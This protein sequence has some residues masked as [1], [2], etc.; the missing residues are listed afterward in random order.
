MFSHS[1]C[2]DNVVCRNEKPPV[3]KQ[4]L[5][6]T[7]QYHNAAITSPIYSKKTSNSKSKPFLQHSIKARH[8]ISNLP[9][10]VH[11][12]DKRTISCLKHSLKHLNGSCKWAAL[13][14]RK[15]GAKHSWTLFE[16]WRHSG[17]MR[18]D[19]KEG[20]TTLVTFFAIKWQKKQQND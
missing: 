5:I 20:E 4:H 9:T 6:S 13:L 16:K 19:K 11:M 15:W 12:G 8:Q 3:C 14:R 7:F 17:P 2:R 1:D 18:G 10:G